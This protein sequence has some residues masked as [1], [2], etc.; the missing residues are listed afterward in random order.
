MSIID[1]VCALPDRK[2]TAKHKEL[3]KSPFVK[4]VNYL[5]K[6]L[7]DSSKYFYRRKGGPFY[8]ERNA[9]N[10]AKEVHYTCH[11]FDRDDRKVFKGTVWVG[12]TMLKR[13][14]CEGVLGYKWV[15]E[16]VLGP[17]PPGCDGSCECCKP[18]RSGVC[19]LKD[20]QKKDMKRCDQP[21]LVKNDT[22]DYPTGLQ[23]G[24]M[25]YPCKT[26]REAVARIDRSCFDTIIIEG[27]F[28]ID[29]TIDIRE[30]MMITTSIGATL[31]NAGEVN[32]AFNITD[33][34]SEINKLLKKCARRFEELFRVFNSTFCCHWNKWVGGHSRL[35]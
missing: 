29:K 12:P 11:Y 30:D 31:M 32:F 7:L 24:S 19:I 6:A 18:L 20:F 23:C 8:K 22:A 1:L 15:G 2:L 35:L 33:E 5:A 21:I 25:K 27:E 14:Y 34:V 3:D 10:S 9:D 4:N 28:L 17:K 13:D 26:I 16:G